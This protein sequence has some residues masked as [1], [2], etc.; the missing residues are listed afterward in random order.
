MNYATQLRQSAM[1]SKAG[2]VALLIALYCSPAAAVTETDK[3]VDRLGVQSNTAYFSVKD[4]LS[5][6][7]KFDIVYLNLGDDFGKAAYANILA[8]QSA[9]RTLS[10]FEYYQAAPG[11]TCTLSLVETRN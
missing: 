3:L 2:I 9:G 5:V 6:K 10:R 4:N 7:C 1:I 8:A 11:E